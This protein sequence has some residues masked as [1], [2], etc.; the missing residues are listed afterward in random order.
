MLGFLSNGHYEENSYYSIAEGVV[1]AFL[2]IGICLSNVTA[3]RI[4]YLNSNSKNDEI[5]EML[6]ESYRIGWFISLPVIVFIIFSA[7]VIVPIYFGAGYDSVIILMK[8]LS[9][10]VLLI[11]FSGITGNQNLIPCK[12]NKTQIAILFAGAALNLIMNLFLIPKIFS[13]GASLS[14]VGA[15]AFI[16]ISQLIIAERYG[17]IKLLHFFKEGLPYIISSILLS[18]CLI[19]FPAIGNPIIQFTLKTF[20]GF[21]IY[22]ITLVLFRDKIV[23]QKLQNMF[24][25]I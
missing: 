24:S 3:P 17:M 8:I 1:K 20:C 7:C 9:P 18:I 6:Y 15:E 14:T 25:H 10:L 12:H 21:A 16:M 2:L 23:Y 4:A 22:L 5:K 19:F 11:T 13:I